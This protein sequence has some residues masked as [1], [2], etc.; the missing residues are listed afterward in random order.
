MAEATLT[1][2]L[3]EPWARVRH[4]AEV[5]GVEPPARLVTDEDT[6]APELMQFYKDYGISLDWIFC[7]DLRR[8]IRDSYEMVKHR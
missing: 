3:A 2:D 5:I 7:G 6:I 8:M 1:D 4:Y